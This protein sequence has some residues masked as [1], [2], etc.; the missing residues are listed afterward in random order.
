M[1]VVTKGNLVVRGIAA[2]LPALQMMDMEPDLFILGCVC[3][4]ALASVAVSPK[5][6]LTHIVVT[7]HLALLVVLTLRYW[8]AFFNGLQQLEVELGGLY[9]HFAHGQDAENPLD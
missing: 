2:Y 8:F 3:S 1:A 7:V 5:H 4:T 6:V 9:D